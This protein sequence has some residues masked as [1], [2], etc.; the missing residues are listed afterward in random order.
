MRKL[1]LKHGKSLIP[2]VHPVLLVTAQMNR[3]RCLPSLI[4]FVGNGYNVIIYYIFTISYLYID[5]I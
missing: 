2:A 1:E 5:S 3:S 4:W